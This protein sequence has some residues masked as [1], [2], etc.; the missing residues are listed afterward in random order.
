MYFQGL[1]V[2]SISIFPLQVVL[3]LKCTFFFIY[4]VLIAAYSLLGDADSLP[5]AA[6]ITPCSV[7]PIVPDVAVSSLYCRGSRLG[8]S[9]YM[10]ST[11]R[12][13]LAPS[14][15]GSDDGSLDDSTVPEDD[16]HEQQKE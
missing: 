9:S 12:S 6:T 1:N 11:V 5:L 3:V 4:C 2:D 16:N 8:R 13:S 15:P 14:S 10:P 7:S